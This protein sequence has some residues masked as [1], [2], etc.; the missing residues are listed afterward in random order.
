MT[1]TAE[2]IASRAPDAGRFS[3]GA[4]VSEQYGFLY[5]KPSI[6]RALTLWGK[7]AESAGLGR[8]ELAYRW[9]VFDSALDAS[10]GDAV[11]FG[12]SRLG[13]IEQTLE[14]FKK[15]SVG[16]EALA[17][18]NELWEGIKDDA[19]LNNID[20]NGDSAHLGKGSAP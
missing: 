11:V 2:Q 12:A 3:E 8:A 10:K 17:R 20:S 7:A 1:K 6:L 19:T 13:Q 15:G 16:P 5:G 14:W 9:I 4:P 18:I